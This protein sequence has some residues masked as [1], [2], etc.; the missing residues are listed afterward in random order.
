MP[1]FGLAGAE[2][3]CENLCYELRKEGIDV[4]VV[5]LYDFHSAI[6]NRIE[7]SGIKVIYLKK[8]RG[9]DISIIYKLR[10]IFKKEKPDVIHTHRYVMQY[11]IPASVGLPIKKRIHTV[12]NVAEKEV[13][14]QQQKLNYFF[15]KYFHVI[16]VA[17]SNEVK[18]SISEVYRIPS[19]RIPVIFNGI[20]LSKCLPKRNY[21]ID[22]VV[23]I[24][25]I[26][27]FSEQKNHNMIIHSYKK[28]L[29]VIPNC[30][31]ILIGSGEL[32]ENIRKLV[33]SLKIDDKVE[34][35]GV[36]SDV[37]TYLHKADIFILPSNYEGMPM[38]LI[39]AMGTGLPIIATNVGGVPSM[40]KNNENGILIKN[41]EEDLFLAIKRLM[42]ENK[43]REL[44]IN[45]RK[46]AINMFSSIKMAEKYIQLY[47]V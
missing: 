11:A 9:L 3:M 37:F 30:K 22:G 29:E 31:L 7:E 20:N 34:F 44:G 12:H 6:T 13:P 4:I 17:L 41:N 15:Y 35:K 38:T 26:G 36:I 21:E 25:H 32:E 10:K 1:D 8:K 24:V 16:P 14:K 33:L 46:T 27:R 45:A 23:K 28:V 40:I 5:S 42:D 47:S 18:E 39:E 2:T 43:R 19:K